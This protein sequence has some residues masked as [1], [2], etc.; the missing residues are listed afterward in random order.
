MIKK[1]QF[2]VF[3]LFVILVFRFKLSLL[4]AIFDIEADSMHNLDSAS[5]VLFSYSVPLQTYFM[6]VFLVLWLL[7]LHDSKAQRCLYSG[8]L[9]HS[10]I[11]WS[12]F[13]VL[14]WIKNSVIR[15]ICVLCRGLHIHYNKYMVAH[16]FL[17]H[18]IAG[19]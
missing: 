19:G 14:I 18:A 13:H 10:I 11:F 8:H 3:Y 16:V 17:I 9:S 1:S 15:G 4:N 2:S 7:M 12:A 6:L 5:L